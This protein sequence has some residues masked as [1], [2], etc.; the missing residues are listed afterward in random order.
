MPSSRSLLQVRHEH[1]LSAFYLTQPHTHTHTLSP[2]FRAL[3]SLSP[4][5]RFL[6]S[7]SV[8]PTHLIKHIHMHIFIQCSQIY[9]FGFCPTNVTFSDIGIPVLCGINRMWVHSSQRRS[10]ICRRLL[11]SVRRNFIIGHHLSL[12]EIAFSQP[13]RDGAALA[14]SYAGTPGNLCACNRRPDY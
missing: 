1:L 4:L 9:F 10:G 12:H 8:S 3:S 7:F 11:D 6:S 2:L 14:A 5:F 13:T